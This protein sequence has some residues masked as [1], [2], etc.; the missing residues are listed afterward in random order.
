MSTTTD[1]LIARNGQKFTDAAAAAITA[2]TI[3]ENY[4]YI[5]INEEAVVSTLTS[6]NGTNLV[7]EI[8]IASKTLSAGMILAAP[9]GEFLTAVTLASGSAFAIKGGQ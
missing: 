3:T 7:T 5:V 2:A 8:G 4:I 1:L 6:S 9:S